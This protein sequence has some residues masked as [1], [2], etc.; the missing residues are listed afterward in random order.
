M[1]YCRWGAGSRSQLTSSKSNTDLWCGRASPGKLAPTKKKHPTIDARKR[2]RE[3][4]MYTGESDAAVA[5][6]EEKSSAAHRVAPARSRRSLLRP[7]SSEAAVPAPGPRF[8]TPRGSPPDCTPDSCSLS[9]DSR[10]GTAGPP[11][12]RRCERCHSTQCS[13][14]S[15]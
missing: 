15:S 7:W 11:R 13:F 8:E 2:E 12:L 14:A 1:S 6:N 10:T 3:K 9:G 5:A 4:G